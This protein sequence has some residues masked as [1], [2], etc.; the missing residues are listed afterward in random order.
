M[1]LGLTYYFFRILWLPLTYGSELTGSDIGLN[2][3]R[4]PCESVALFRG[5][6]S[7]VDLSPQVCIPQFLRQCAKSLATGSHSQPRARKVVNIE[8]GNSSKSPIR[9]PR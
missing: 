8:M 1:L 4:D 3:A 5:N 2:H 9:L 7:T 6:R